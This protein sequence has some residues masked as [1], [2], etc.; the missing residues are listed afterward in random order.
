[1]NKT[2]KTLLTAAVLTLSSVASAQER[3]V[4]V[5]ST[6]YTGFYS[7]STRGDANQSLSFVPFGAKFDINGYLLSPDLISYSV[8]PELAA[9]PQASEAG[10]QGG[11]GVR[12]RVTFLRKRTFPLTFRY[13]NVQVQDVYFGSLSQISGYRLQNRNKDLGVTWESH[14]AKGVDLIFDGGKSSVNSKS[15]IAQ[16]PD[17]VSTQNHL[18]ADAKVD[19]RGWD[20]EG[21]IHRQ[22]QTSNLLTEAGTN[23]IANLVQNVLQYQASV[24]KG[25]WGDSEFYVDGGTQSTSSSLFALPIDLTTHYGNM[26]IRLLQR[27]KW[28]TNVRVGYSSNVA[29]QLLAQATATLATPGAVAIGTDIL[30]P[31][32]RSISNLNMNA[33]E[34]GDLGHGIGLYFTV[35]HN[36]VLGSSLA[37]L[38]GSNYTTGTAGITYTHNFSWGTFNGQYGRDLGYG[39]VTGQTG[40]IDGQIYRVGLQHRSS[41]GMVFDVS[42]HG[43]NQQVRNAQPLSNDSLSVEGSVGFRVLTDFTAR[44]GGGWQQSDFSTTANDFRTH[45]YLAR[46]SIE[47]PRYQFSAYMNDSLSDSLPI[48]NGLLGI[49]L[50]SVIGNTLQII[51]SDY[52]SIGFAFHATPVRKLEVSA[53]WTH[54]RQH[55]DGLLTNDFELL[56][57]YATYRFRKLLM[58]AGYIRFN[59]LFAFYPSTYRDRFYLRFQ[60]SA[61]IL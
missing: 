56:N 39:S 24:R 59:Q 33:T 13:S 4:T 47:H 49:G 60:R 38:P 50:G 28:R 48:Y 3:P 21:F 44:L 7:T 30:L 41:N 40:T 6:F 57:L 22:E 5:F 14:P 26:N 29:S 45:G 61:R 2:P 42:V 36:E 25:F 16:I 20:V 23:N 43:S 18:N 17:Y 35:E 54:S 11:N 32:S 12:L 51:P 8:Q 27:R 10:I 52:R 15:D 37:G 53:N 19:R 55:L 31:F 34:T 58:E 46:F 1:M 9:G